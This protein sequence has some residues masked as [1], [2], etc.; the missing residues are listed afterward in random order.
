MGWFT[1]TV[2]LEP[3]SKHIIFFVT[4]KLAQKARVLHNIRLQRLSNVK[5]SNLLVQ[6]V[7]YEEKKCCEYGP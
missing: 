4:Y 1:P 5:R 6:F 7:S 2:Y 3:Y